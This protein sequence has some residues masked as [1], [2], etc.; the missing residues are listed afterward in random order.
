MRRIDRCHQDVERKKFVLS[1]ARWI[2]KACFQRRGA[3]QNQRCRTNKFQTNDL[4]NRNGRQRRRRRCHNQVNL[5][6]MGRV[7]VVMVFVLA[8]VF[9]ARGLAQMSAF[10]PGIKVFLGG[11]VQRGVHLEPSQ[12]QQ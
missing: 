1:M 2:A 8:F 6:I 11:Q 10:E 4:R 12:V 5:V 3:G 9:I 7:R